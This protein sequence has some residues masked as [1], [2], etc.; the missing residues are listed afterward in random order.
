MNQLKNL[1]LLACC[2]LLLN[3]C[4][5]N[6]KKVPNPNAPM[7]NGRQEGEAAASV[8]TA[9]QERNVNNSGMGQPAHPTAT[10]LAGAYSLAPSL[11]FVTGRISAYNNKMELWRKRDSQAAVLRIPADESEKM[12]NCFRE[13]QKILNG[14]NRLHETL[15]RQASLPTGTATYNPKEVYELQQ[16]DVAFVDGF[17]GQVVAADNDSGF[18]VWGQGNGG[19]GLLPVEILIAQHAANGQHEELVQAWEQ[20]PEVMEAKVSVQTK[21]FYGNALMAL[22]REEEAAQMYRSLVDQM[23]PADGPAVDLLSVRKVLADLYFATQNY[24]EAEAQYNEISKNYKDATAVEEWAILQ[25]TIL[26]K[27]DQGG[28][29]LQEYAGLLKNN[30]GFEPTKDGYA[31]VW[32]ADKFL[33]VYPKSPVA[34]NV[35][36][37][38]SA[39][40]EQ[41][42]QW[43]KSNGSDAATLAGQQQPQGAVAEAVVP[44]SFDQF[45]PPLPSVPVHSTAVRPQFSQKNE[46]GAVPSPNE[47]AAANVENAQE[48]ERRWGEGQRLMAEAQYDKAIEMFTP[49]L[50]SQDSLKAEKKIAEASM[51]AAEAERRRAADIFIRFTKAADVESRKKLLIE[52]RRILLDILVKYPG[53]EVTDKVVGNIK[54]V[55]KE[56]NAIDPGL[57]QSGPIGGGAVRHDNET[58]AL[59]K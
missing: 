20:M 53:V 18:G 22:Q 11:E 48:L 5:S 59:G 8:S 21:I 14:Y 57:L 7:E 25:R 10:A 56:M 28:S 35:D 37:M 50:N 24:R 32:Q 17:C 43:S 15:L 26:Q 39:V 2:S 38:R 31:V 33:Q 30:L 54:R 52:S 58:S 49:M 44:N 13:L 46:N 4:F 45:P 3:G 23:A 1:A 34:F 12:V 29:E 27:G 55:E 41:A 42:D 36:L 19:N 51:F 9:V 47:T 16:G 6:G 40:R